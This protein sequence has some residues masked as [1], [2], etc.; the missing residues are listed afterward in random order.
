MQNEIIS[1][2]WVFYSSTQHNKLVRYLHM[3]TYSV[4]LLIYKLQP[5]YIHPFYRLHHIH[6]GGIHCVFVCNH[7]QAEYMQ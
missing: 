2:N 5:P 4:G 7:V 3:D 6:I 1:K